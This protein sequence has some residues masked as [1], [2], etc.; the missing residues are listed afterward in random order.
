VNTN[1]DKRAAA[2]PRRRGQALTRPV[3]VAATLAAL[4]GAAVGAYFLWFNGDE[5]D[6]P[7]TA[8]VREGPLTISVTEPGTIQ[9]RDRLTHKS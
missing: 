5:A 9:N 8:T 7:I 1:L 6:Q 4:A 3:V 2:P